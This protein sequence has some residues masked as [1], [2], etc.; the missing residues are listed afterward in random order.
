MKHERFFAG[1]TAAVLSG[2]LAIGAVGCVATG[3][4]LDLES[5]R[6]VLFLCAASAVLFSALF[7]LKWG[8]P[9]AACLLALLSGWLW[10]RGIAW[11]QLLSLLVRVSKVYHG[12]YDWGYF[13]FAEPDLPGD[14]PLAVLGGLIG[15]LSSYALVRRKSI[16]LPLSLSGLALASCLVVT[17][18][19]PDTIYLFALL[20]AFLLC[21]IPQ[22][23]RRESA[24][25]G[26]RLTAL[27]TLPVLLALS[28]LFLAVPKEGYVDRS[29]ELQAAILN[30]L[31]ELPQKLQQTSDRFVTGLPDDSQKNL[32]LK[33][34]GPRPR[35]THAVMDITADTD[36]TLYLRGQ[37]YDAYTGT[38][39]TASPHR[40][41]P[42]GLTD[43]PNHSLSLSTR[44]KKEQL[45]L[46]Y[47]AA[48]DIVLA[49][50]SLKN[51]QGLKEYAFDYTVLPEDW[52][53]RLEEELVNVEDRLALTNLEISQFGS[54]ADRLRY[55]TLPGKTK[56]QAE[57][58]LET[59]L[60]ENAHR[61]ETADAI[62]EFVKNSA[63]YDLNTGRMPSDEED[64]ALWFLEEGDTGYCVHFATAAVVLLRAADIP[65]R[66]VTGY[67]TQARAGESV[68]VTAG[69]SHAWAEYYVPQ[70]EAWVVLEATPT[71]E[72]LVEVGPVTEATDAT[73]TIP[74][75][76]Q[77]SEPE[78]A[79]PSTQ[80]ALPSE[81]EEPAQAPKSL[82]WL[83]WLL[84]LLAVAAVLWVQRVLRLTHL[85]KR[86]EAGTPNQRALVRWTETVR[87]CRLQ[88]QSPPD[89]LYRLAQRAKFSQHTLSDRELTQFDAFLDQSRRELQKRPW[90]LQIAYRLVFVVY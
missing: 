73:Q 16:L 7:S 37:D 6:T 29:E 48:G 55:V 38:G 57:A 74:V 86:M 12:A 36:G 30:H 89:S 49:G 40:A 79:L 26:Y 52:Q 70:L 23:V 15:L 3:F 22:S 45:F 53:A 75:Q 90:Y 28:V 84:A 10:H 18:T 69:D 80:P 34:L 1:L 62:A 72:V 31:E 67:L 35:Y 71:E 21:M 39:W 43:T 47:Y 46:P 17:D 85:R 81:P 77:G 44:T 59:F 65:A 76:T 66:Y 58:L 8:G 41:E 2:L 32:N 25:Q 88:K 33:G 9:A 82:G 78:E 51:T 64:F 24:A 83:W 42:F 50:G 14:Y 4:R 5:L 56:L 60:P 63:E 19:V 13:L 20:A 54:T 61:W 87:L 11:D 68:T 27:I